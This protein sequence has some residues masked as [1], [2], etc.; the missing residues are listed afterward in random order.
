MSGSRTEGSVSTTSGEVTRYRWS[1]DSEQDRLP[2]ED[3]ATGAVITVVQGGGAGEVNA[4][5]E[6][7]HRAFEEDWRWR[8]SAERARLLLECADVLESHADEMAELVSRENGKPIIDARQIDINI[9][10]GEFRFFGSLVDKLPD[11][12]YDRGNVYVKVVHEPLGVVGGIIP[13][14]WPPIHTAGKIAPAIAM[15]NTVVLKPSEQAP[16]TTMRIVELLNMVLPPDVVDAVPGFGPTAGQALVANPLV[17]MVSFT[18]SAK[19]GAAVGKT[20]AENITHVLLKLGGK[21]PLIIFDDADIDSVVRAALEGGYFNKGEACTAASRVIVQRGIH[22][23]F[24]ERLSAGVR[25]LKTG[26]GADPTTHVGPLVTRA[27]QQK[28]LDYIRIGVEE[29]A[30]V[31]AQGALPEDPK[32]AKG[33][34][35]APTL[36]DGVTRD[37]RIAMEEIFGPVVSVITFDS[38]D[39]AL[40]IANESEYGLLSSVFT[41]DSERLFRVARGIEAGMV[42]ANNYY[43]E[44]VGTPFGGIKHSG[45]GREH[46]IETLREF[47]YEKLIRYPSGTGSIPAWR[48]VSDVYGSS[49]SLVSP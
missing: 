11:D 35:V 49:G 18:G 14:N 28:V 24:V 7:A 36:F 38:E 6:A 15:G 31:V 26:S 37:M 41:R 10:I 5:V 21:N 44:I 13:F 2:V 4:A 39:E 8:P 27:Q 29:G 22:D 16:L 34:Y 3:P 19:A 32:L 47:S 30:T 46:A 25:A 45:H 42:L 12:L 43:R 40:A 1:S 48:A 20:A 33:F 9:L 17:R 23:T